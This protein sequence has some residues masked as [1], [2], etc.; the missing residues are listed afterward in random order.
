VPSQPFPAYPPAY[1]LTDARLTGHAH[2]IPRSTRFPY[3]QIGSKARELPGTHQIIGPRPP[4]VNA[5][6]VPPKLRSVPLKVSCFL[7]PRPASSG[8]WPGKRQ[9]IWRLDCTPPKDSTLAEIRSVSS[10]CP[11]LKKML[12]PSDGVASPEFYFPHR[13]V[14]RRPV[15]GHQNRRAASTRSGPSSQFTAAFSVHEASHPEY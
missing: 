13:K 4:R 9:I 8:I 3:Q 10:V 1:S 6:W 2:H 11:R 15:T 14:F 12:H 7:D 5:E